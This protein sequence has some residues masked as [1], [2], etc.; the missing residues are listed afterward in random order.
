[1][2]TTT[3]ALVIFTTLFFGTFMPTIRN[4]LFPPKNGGL[5]ED[6]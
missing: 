6:M 1:M 2:I 3:L 4:I 5:D